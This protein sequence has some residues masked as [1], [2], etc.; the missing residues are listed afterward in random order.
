MAPPVQSAG[1][2]YQTADW[3]TIAT[4]K[5]AP[6]AT[7]FTVAAGDLLVVLIMN[8]GA[9]T[10]STP[11]NTGTAT[12]T[13]TQQVSQGASGS[14]CACKVF[15]GAVTGGG[16]VQLSVTC[17]GTGAF[18]FIIG[19]YAAANN[20]G[21]GT[22]ANAIVTSPTSGAPVATP[23]APWT[24]NSTVWCVNGDWAATAHG[25]TRSY[26]TNI[27][28]TTEYNY[29]QVDSNY[30]TEAWIHADTGAAP[31][32]G[33]I[34]LTTPTTQVYSVAGI[35][36]LGVGGAAAPAGRTFQPQRMPLGV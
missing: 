35:E 10:I 17:G 4:T 27:G 2:P 16:T 6:A 36:V 23:V 29:I 32:S 21:V 34:G 11:T 19:A 12:I 15:S 1:S 28:A 24:A 5:T 8:E 7:T 14:N 13:M 3:N 31:G 20:G 25:A 26:R 22:H 18:G 30:S 33:T 9:N